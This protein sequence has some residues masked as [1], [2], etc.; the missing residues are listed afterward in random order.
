MDISMA[1]TRKI[2]I[3][4]FDNVELL[5]IAGPHDVFATA[6]ALASGN[7]PIYD[8]ATAAPQPG[9]VRSSSGLL[10]QPT[11]AIGAL[12]EVHTLLIAGGAGIHDL[13]NNPEIVDWLKAIAPR[14]RR[15]GSICTGAFLLGAAGLLSGKRA[16]T[17]WNWCDRLGA[18][19][20]DIIVERDPIYVTDKGVWTSA[21]VTAGIDMALAMIEEDH[22]AKLALRTAQE[23][24]VFRK[25]PGGQSQFS[26]ELALHAA[27][28]PPLDRLRDW[29]LSHL[30]ADL[31]VA[32]LAARAGMSSRNFS[33][34]FQS[35]T[36][37]TP[38][39]FVEIARLEAARSRLETSSDPIERV[40]AHCGFGS[41]D[42]MARAM[43]RQLGVTPADYRRR[44]NSAWRDTQSENPQHADV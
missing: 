13:C 16:V 2:A 20:P 19:H 1:Q 12:A 30:D 29:I 14:L 6:A 5:D 35:N 31:S 33:R 25:R 39:K 11:V 37:F 38:A 40:A 10:F 28:S 21:G 15:L 34:A 44:F 17:H 24:V 18:R 43:L 36:R 26:A 22:G 7:S 42:V 4:V 3:L 8:V 27:F 32:A 41:A 23:L 9:A